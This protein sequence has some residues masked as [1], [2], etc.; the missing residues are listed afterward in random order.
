M[1][2]NV[3]PLAAVRSGGKSGFGGR[4]RTAVTVCAALAWLGVAGFCMALI[5]QYTVV[6]G[7][8]GRPPA[9]WPAESRI[10]LNPNLPTLVL[11]AH[12]RCPCTRA[13]IGELD[14]LMARV[15]GR[16]KAEVWFLKPD[17]TAENWT[18]TDL[19]SSAAAIPGVTV[20]ED[21]SGREASLFRVATSGET[22]LYDPDGKLVFQGGITIAR[23]HAGDNPG[24]SALADLVAGSLTNQVQTPVYGC[25]LFARQ[26]QSGGAD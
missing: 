14:L 5:Q 8:A 11:F 26:C 7:D 10:P 21:R 9:R 4:H 19:W 3:V 13:T 20:H 24:R 18:N 22:L 17:D 16:L 6:P 1:T 15:Q 25:P 2:V 12:P 23:G